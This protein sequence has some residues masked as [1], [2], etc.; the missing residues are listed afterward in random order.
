MKKTS[1]FM[2][3]LFTFVMVSPK[4]SWGAYLT[5]TDLTRACSSGEKEQQNMCLGYIAGMIDYHNLMRSLGT[6]PTVDF[7]IP[8]QVTLGAAAAR[9]AQY[10]VMQPQHDSFIAA[11]AVTLALYQ[12]YPC[13]GK[14]KA[15]K[16]KK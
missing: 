1:F 7:C 2:I 5:G 4:L 16:K 10:L 11:P 13:G 3:F 15:R 9:V 8:N 12:A 6:S 14:S